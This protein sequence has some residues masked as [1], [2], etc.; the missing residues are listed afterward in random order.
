MERHF[1]QVYIE[2]PRRGFWANY[3]GEKSLKEQVLQALAEGTIKDGAYVAFTSMCDR[4][5][6]K[7]LIWNQNRNSIKFVSEK[8]GVEVEY[9]T[10]EGDMVLQMLKF[11]YGT[12]DEPVSKIGQNSYEI[13][14]K[15]YMAKSF[16]ERLCQKHK[17][18]K[19]NVS[20]V[21]AHYRQ[22][23]EE[24]QGTSMMSV[25]YKTGWYSYIRI[26]GL[27][28]LQIKVSD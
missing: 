3:V 1:K 10:V 19:K 21:K 22:W 20:I 5:S 14:V 27:N 4:Q 24:C 11:M 17:L 7:Y 6:E 18:S 2:G 8:P 25:D 15:D 28:K 23:F 12:L 9:K 26:S 16:K 13:T